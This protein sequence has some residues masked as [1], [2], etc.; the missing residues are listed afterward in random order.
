MSATAES[1]AV[2]H[3]Y[4]HGFAS[5]PASKKA[6]I[7]R[8]R[9]AEAG[10]ELR[11]PDLAAGDFENLTITGQLELVQREARGGRVRLVGSSMGGYLAA[12]YAARHPEAERLVLL[13]PAFDFVRRWPATFG[14]ARFQEWERTGHTE[15]FHF[16]DQ[17][18]RRLSFALYRDA[19]DYE[20]YPEVSAPCLIFHGLRDEVAPVECSREFAR[21]HPGAELRLLDDNHE[22]L[23]E[24]DN[25]CSRALNFLR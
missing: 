4:L 21:R 1:T 24:I 19:S 25:I 12:L 7:F 18:T 20:P 23:V 22:L 2:R 17:A 11:V 6:A 9:F 16:G 14:V 15:V 10:I 3:L 13:A 5:G 8:N